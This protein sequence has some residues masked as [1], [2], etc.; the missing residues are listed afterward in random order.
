MMAPMKIINLVRREIC[1]G[2]CLFIT[3]PVAAGRQGAVVPAQCQFI[4]VFF[5]PANFAPALPSTI[6]EYALFEKSCGCRLPDKQLRDSGQRKTSP[7]G[8][9]YPSRCYGLVAVF[10]S[11]LEK[12][13]D[14]K[15][16]SYG[17]EF[18]SMCG[19]MV[20]ISFRQ[21]DHISE[22]ITAKEGKREKTT[23][24]I[25]MRVVAGT[26]G[27]DISCS[28]GNCRRQGCTGASPAFRTGDVDRLRGMSSDCDSGN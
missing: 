15:R 23:R 8:N 5:R 28:I 16:T 25:C 6:K 12:Y 10:F 13:C 18:A 27:T 21:V 1:I 9:V 14:T 24:K 22:N 17:T 3:V 19:N 20:P 7:I 2:K 11:A 4:Q 26:I